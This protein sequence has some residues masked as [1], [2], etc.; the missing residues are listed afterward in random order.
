MAGRLLEI[1]IDSVLSSITAET[2]GADRVELCDNL[3]EGGT[4]PSAG[5]ISL[6]REK[7]TIGLQVMIRPRGGDFLYTDEEYEVMKRDIQT[8]KELGADG[9]V[10]GLLRPDG[11]IDKK[12][13]N[14]LIR[15]ARP[16]SITFHRAFDM[17][18]NPE[19]SLEDLIELGVDRLL[20]S[21]L[22]ATVIC[23]KRVIKQLVDQSDGRIEVMAGGGVRLH[24]IQELVDETG[25]EQIHASGRK[26]QESDMIF[27]NDKVQMGIID[28]Q[29]YSVKVGDVD[30]IK[31]F[32]KQLSSI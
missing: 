9:V 14:E 8:A 28:N 17:V 20:T 12:R 11:A 7:I 18:K 10:F 13:C 4:T 5:M 1:C 19:Q 25:V 23:G 16:M 27:R 3:M 22:H 26:T 2:G 24:N 30:L 31:A 15:L 21:G 29:E 32:R 6:V